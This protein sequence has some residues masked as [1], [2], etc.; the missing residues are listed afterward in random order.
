M[1]SFKIAKM[2]FIK[3]EKFYRR[4]YSEAKL[5]HCHTVQTSVKFTNFAEETICIMTSYTLSLTVVVVDPRRLD[6]VFLA[7]KPAG[8]TEMLSS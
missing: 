7:G 5:P 2:W 4:F 3:F 6:L 8:S 1:T